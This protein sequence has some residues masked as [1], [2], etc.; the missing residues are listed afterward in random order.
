MKDIWQQHKRL[1]KFGIVLC[2]IVLI[3]GTIEIISAIQ[4]ERRESSAGATAEITSYTE[5]FKA[6]D[7]EGMTDEEIEQML[8]MERQ[9]NQEE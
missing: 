3:W 9:R 2:L 6:Y 8:E 7:V 5:P 1:L 4:L